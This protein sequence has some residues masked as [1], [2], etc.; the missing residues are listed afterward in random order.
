MV[1]HC[2]P[3]FNSIRLKSDLS[4][5]LRPAIHEAMLGVNDWL[6]TFLYDIT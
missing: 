2:Q 1:N 4:E 3:R 6:S 5:A